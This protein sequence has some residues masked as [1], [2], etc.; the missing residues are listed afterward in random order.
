MWLNSRSRSNG[1]ARTRL[2]RSLT[3]CDGTRS[4]LITILPLLTHSGVGEVTGL[5][6]PDAAAFRKPLAVDNPHG[7]SDRPALGVNRDTT[8]SKSRSGMV[9]GVSREPCAIQAAPPE[10]HF[11]KTKLSIGGRMRS[12]H[13]ADNRGSTVKFESCRSSVSRSPQNACSRRRKCSKSRRRE[14]LIRVGRYCLDL[15]LF[16]AG[17]RRRRLVQQFDHAFVKPISHLKAL[18]GPG[19][20]ADHDIDS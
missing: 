18:G 4:I 16:S 20:I 8:C 7:T 10:R 11:L 13:T 2:G 9:F 5:L 3:G 17:L 1:H 12:F 6:L 14:R 15:R 19:D